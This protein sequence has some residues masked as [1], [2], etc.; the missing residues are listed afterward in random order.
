[1]PYIHSMLY[2]ICHNAATSHQY[3]ANTVFMCFRASWTWRA[4]LAYRYIMLGKCNILVLVYLHSHGTGRY[5]FQC[6]N[7]HVQIPM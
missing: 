6:S 5:M 2:V 7:I 4:A 1:M 3:M